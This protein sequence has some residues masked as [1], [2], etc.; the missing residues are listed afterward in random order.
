MTPVQQSTPSNLEKIVGRITNLPTP[1]M[2]LDQIN[3]VISDPRTSAFDIASILSEDAAM[4]AKVLRLSN[5]AYYG[6]RQEVSSVRQAV[7][8]LGIEAIRSLVLSSAVFDMF[9]GKNLDPGF[10]DRHWRHSLGTAISARLIA[11]HLKGTC[12]I[13]CDKAFSAGL[14][15]DVGK[16]IMCAFLPEDFASVAKKVD[17]DC[18][19]SLKAE[20]LVL[21]YTHSELGALFAERWKLPQQI[22]E[23]IRYHHYPLKAEEHKAD[24]QIIHLA[25]YVSRSTFV[26]DGEALAI[27]GIVSREVYDL[28]GVSPADVEKLRI[29]LKEE[30]AKAETFLKMASAA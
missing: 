13:E 7:V 9:R 10:L 21:N 30:Y 5:S 25:D 11:R 27:G 4:S 18:I 14:L 24:V 29:P 16:L 6:M 20:E 22:V 19:S 17:E 28:L 1:P 23:S 12:G 15:H 2:V 3:K 26:S 8:I